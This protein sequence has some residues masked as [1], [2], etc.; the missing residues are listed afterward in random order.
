MVFDAEF[1][2]F[3]VQLGVGGSIA[4]II[5]FFYRKDVRSYTDLWQAQTA[6][7]DAQVAA[8]IKVVA[9]NSANTAVNTE[10]LK[11]LHKRIDRLD[12]LRIVGNEAEV[13]ASDRRS[14]S[15]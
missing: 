12:L 3:L 14:G 11:S 8:M 2:K 7:S 5:F 10:V 13:E 15:T 6:R 9:E 1:L 4:G